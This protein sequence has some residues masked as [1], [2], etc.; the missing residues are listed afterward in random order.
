MCARAQVNNGGLVV[1]FSWAELQQHAAAFGK[2]FVA[3]AIPE[4]RIL[5]NYTFFVVGQVRG[6]PPVLPP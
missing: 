4:S 5:L 1:P 6:C 3:K 2:L